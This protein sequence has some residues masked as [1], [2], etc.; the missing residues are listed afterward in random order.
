VD[1]EGERRG[2]DAEGDGGGGGGLEVAHGEVGDVSVWCKA[3][4]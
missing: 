3:W 4:W 1:F 2:V